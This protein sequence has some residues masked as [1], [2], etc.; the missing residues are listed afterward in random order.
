MK[1][2]LAAFRYAFQ[3]ILNGIR[4][5]AHMRFH[6]LAAL[7]VLC[8]AWYFQV[9]SWEWCILVLCIGMVISAELFNAAVERL[10]DRVSK[11]QDPLIGAAKDLAAGAVL[12]LS[13]AALVAGSII[14]L[15]RIW[16]LCF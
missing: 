8:L 16:L 2:R 3:G 13:I 9:Q 14:F 6:L 10:A 11:E 4:T 12:I 5:E 15:P 7:V 1:N